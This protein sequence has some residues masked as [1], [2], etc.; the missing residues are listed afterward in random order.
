MINGNE[1]ILLWNDEPIACLTSNSLSEVL[2]FLATSKKTINGAQTVKPVA[3][4]YSLNF[5]AVMT[6]DGP[7]SWAD[8]SR[9]ARAMRLGTWG[10]DLGGS[11]SG[12]AGFGFLSNLEMTASSGELIIFTG[13]II[14]YGEITTYPLTLNVWYQDVDTPVDEGGNYVLVA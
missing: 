10:F 11:M 5:E 4:F 12:D 13:T 8:L 7:M 9:L 6:S 2:S 14:G 3:N 1:C